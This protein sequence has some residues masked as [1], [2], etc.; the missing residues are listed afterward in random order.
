MID[1]ITLRVKDIGEAKIFY[2]AVLSP[3]GYKCSVDQEFD[4]VR[5]LGFERDGK[6][7]TW[8]TTDTP[9]SGPCH[10]AWRAEARDDVEAFYRAALSAG[11]VDNGAPGLR[12]HYHSN[13]YSAFVHDP[14]GHNI[15][16]VCHSPSPK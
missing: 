3:I 6:T 13:Y 9:T 4:A 8:F 7:D 14:N 15:E 1:H 16:V 11:A 5:V 12:E 2:T 10:I